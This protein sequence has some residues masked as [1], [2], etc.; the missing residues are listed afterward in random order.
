MQLRFTCRCAVFAARAVFAFAPLL[1]C[2]KPIAQIAS[3]FDAIA[4]AIGNGR[5]HESL[6][7]AEQALLRH[8]PP[9]ARTGLDVGCGDGVLTRALARRGVAM[10]AIDV[11]P[12]MIDLARAR[13]DR[14]MMVDYRV[15][16][17]M[18]L[19]LPP[20][21]FDVVMSVNT[22]HHMELERVVPRLVACVAPG[23][24]LLIQDV[25]TRNGVRA[26]PINVVASVRRRLR[27][28]LTPSRI[29]SRVA[30]LYAQHGIGES[31][32]TPERV[33]AEYQAILPDARI[34]QHL[35]WRYSVIWT[36]P[37]AHG[38]ADVPS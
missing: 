28:L 1:L 15:G 6:M 8:V 7:P 16:D 4:D 22:V 2:M 37:S 33:V 11:S 24:T 25:V 18:T 23:G 21:A 3:D 32:L 35:E 10:L 29:S 36:R 12:K 27:R 38:T 20:A 31:Y 19:S 13:T 14:G 30:S 9:G 17:F 34:E 26:L 5:A